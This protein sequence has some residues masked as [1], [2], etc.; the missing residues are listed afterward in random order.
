M[1]R[2]A[3]SIAGKQH[4]EIGARDAAIDELKQQDDADD[5]LDDMRRMN[6]DTPQHHTGQ[7]LTAEINDQWNHR[8]AELISMLPPVTDPK[9]RK[10]HHKNGYLLRFVRKTWSKATSAAA[11]PP[12]SSSPIAA[13]T[14]ESDAATAAS[15]SNINATE[16]DTYWTVTKFRPAQHGH[17]SKVWGYLTWRGVIQTKQGP[18]SRHSSGKHP[19]IHVIRG[20]RRREWKLLPNTDWP[21]GLC[22]DKAACERLLQIDVSGVSEKE[23]IE[24]PDVVKQRLLNQEQEQQEREGKEQQQK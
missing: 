7:L 21:P 13:D 24:Q 20:H 17:K 19:E 2:V 16:T 11:V 14:A 15:T 10:L 9:L 3:A 5:E 4:T 22:T 6:E 23:C 18:N 12:S 8:I 1:K